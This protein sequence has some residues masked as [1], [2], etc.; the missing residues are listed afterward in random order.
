MSF[1]EEPAIDQ[2][3][4]PCQRFE[5]IAGEFVGDE[6]LAFPPTTNRPSLHPFAT[7]DNPH[8][9]R[10]QYFSSQYPNPGALDHQA[11]RSRSSVA[12]RC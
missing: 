2:D 5:A 8:D 7:S 6:F 1:V 11:S 3:T 12:I 9:N 10:K 4:L